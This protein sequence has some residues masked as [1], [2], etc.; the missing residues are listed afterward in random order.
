MHLPAR[1]PPLHVPQCTG[2]GP[3][4]AVFCSRAAPPVIPD[5]AASNGRI[6]ADNNEPRSKLRGLFRS[7]RPGS[8]G[9]VALLADITALVENDAPRTGR[10]EPPDGG[11]RAYLLAG[12]IED[13]SGAE[14]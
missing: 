9:L 1:K 14:R 12:R 8:S 6:A 3:K 4:I 13:R 5:H 11:E 10:L 2:S 7:A